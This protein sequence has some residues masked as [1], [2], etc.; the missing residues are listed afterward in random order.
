M[1]YADAAKN[2]ADKFATGDDGQRDFKPGMAGMPMSYMYL[3][4]DKEQ[5][6]PEVYGAY[7]EKS[8]PVYSI[9]TWKAEMLSSLPLRLYK[10]VETTAN[11]NVPR[12]VSVERALYLVNER[13]KTYENRMRAGTPF[14]M[15]T[16]GA[17]MRATSPLDV[18]SMTRRMGLEE[19]NGGKAYDLLRYVN[20][21]W[22]PL[23]LYYMSSMSLDVYAENYWFLERGESGKGIPREIWWAKPTQVRPV[24]DPKK[25]II[26]YWYVPVE[27]GEW[28]FFETS[29]V[30]RFYRPHLRDQFQPLSPLTSTRIYADHERTSM[31][32][33]MNLHRQGLSPGA[34][35][36][37]KDKKIWSEE[38]A[39][40]IEGKV[41]ARMGGYDKAHK[42]MVFRQEIE[43]HTTGIS[44]KDS[45]FIGGMGYDL[46]RIANAYHFPIDLL[47]GKRTYENVDQALKMA[48]QT[49]VSQGAFIAAQ[50]VEEFF[51]MFPGGDETQVAFF[52]HSG[53]SVLQENETARWTREKEQIDVVI[54]RNEW[55][56]DRGMEVVEGGDR[57]FVSNQQTPLDS[58]FFVTGPDGE[59]PAVPATPAKE[60]AGQAT[61]ASSNGKAAQNG[62]AVK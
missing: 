34:V 27:G 45:E 16:I 48:W 12:D 8:N 26:G 7:L 43:K 3:G 32:A 24:T 14:A 62:A 39:L 28:T 57:L 19:V 40:D 11:F 29:E 1:S 36:T 30:I 56:A 33:N 31:E 20:P 58:P 22:T 44:P 23:Q 47:G 13:L 21:F 4:V 37:P 42:W 55:R 6:S 59:D 38:Q 9:A 52:D 53:V 2:F 15:N 17:L 10:F 25:Y 49:V 60:T 18:L 51:P 46:E 50:L 5:Q 35:I 54:R 61:L 41:N